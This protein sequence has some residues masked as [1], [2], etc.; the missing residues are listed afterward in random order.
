[1]FKIK[2]PVDNPISMFLVKRDLQRHM[3]KIR[4]YDE[5]ISFKNLDKLSDMDLDLLCF[6]RG[7]KLDQTKE[8]KTR[9]LILWLTISN[10][11]NVSD[12]LLLYT[13]INDY[14]KD[15]FDVDKERLGEH[16][17]TG[18]QNEEKFKEQMDN[19][20]KTFG[21]NKLLDAV[22]QLGKHIDSKLISEQI[23]DS[24]NQVEPSI[25]VEDLKIINDNF[26]EFQQ[27]HLNI[28]E[29]MENTDEI[30]NKLS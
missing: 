13:R 29:S 26:D 5:M 8:E 24:Q 22:N 20:E 14:T 12:Q 2:I 3:L 30:G 23:Q 25:S 28:R 21:V 11:R 1:M 27:R 4:E 18:I 6:A 9:S 15:L 17:V 16:V 19:F 7:I 10:Q